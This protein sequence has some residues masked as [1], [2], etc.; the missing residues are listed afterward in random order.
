MDLIREWFN[1][2]ETY[3][4]TWKSDKGV[5]WYLCYTNDPWEPASYGSEPTEEEALNEIKWKIGMY[6]DKKGLV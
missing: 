3:W 1:T 2:R 6:L 4:N 5:S